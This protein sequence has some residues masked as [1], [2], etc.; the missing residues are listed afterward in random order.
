MDFELTEEQRDIQKAAREF[1]ETEFGKDYI[2]DLEL[3][4]KYPWG[5]LQKASELAFITIDFPEE[6]GEQGYG[7]LEKALALE[8]LCRVGA[9]VG[10]DVGAS[11]FA[12]KILLKS[13][14]EEQKK[15]YLTL[16]CN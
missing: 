6:Y 13:G 7:F 4:H 12:S 3:N 2:L 11:Q 16:V 14:S 9:G 1:A 8:E 10:A 15:K 5:L